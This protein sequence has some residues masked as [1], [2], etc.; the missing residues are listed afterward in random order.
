MYSGSVK[1]DGTCITSVSMV[2]ETGSQVV[3]WLQLGE[4]SVRR[5]TFP[6]TTVNLRNKNQPDALF[7]LIY[8]NNIL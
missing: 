7:F 5:Q 4:P 2:K 3:H 1:T 8:S 6:D